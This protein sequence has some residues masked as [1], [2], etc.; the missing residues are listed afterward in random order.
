MISDDENPFFAASFDICDEVS[1]ARVTCGRCT[2]PAT[3]CICAFLPAEPLTLQ[4]SEVFLLQ[5]PHEENRRMRTAAILE[6]C[7]SGDSLK[8]LKGRRFSVQKNP[9]VY[10]GGLL[11]Y[12]ALDAVP[13]KEV[14]V[15]PD[16][17]AK[18]KLIVID[19]TWKQAAEMYA[20]NPPLHLLRKVSNRQV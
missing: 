14:G 5:H 4:R 20:Q 10:A 13:L 19:G 17:P 15:V 8:I 11:L 2:R 6:A 18:Y 1:T 16:P 12:P 7:I 3:A 9:D